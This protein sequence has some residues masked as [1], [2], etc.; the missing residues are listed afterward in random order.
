MPIKGNFK[1]DWFG[2]SR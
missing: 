1:L 2:V